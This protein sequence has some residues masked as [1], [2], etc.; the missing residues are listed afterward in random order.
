[1]LLDHVEKSRAELPCSRN[2]LV[3]EPF[4][5]LNGTFNASPLVGSLTL[6]TPASISL[7]NV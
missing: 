7:A 4:A 3:D 2:I 5:P 1:M 6:T